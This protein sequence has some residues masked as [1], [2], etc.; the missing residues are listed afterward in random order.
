MYFTNIKKKKLVTRHEGQTEAA[1]RLRLRVRFNR[2]DGGIT[3][4][5]LTDDKL[6]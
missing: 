6:K 2:R 3:G 5:N 1:P 4:H